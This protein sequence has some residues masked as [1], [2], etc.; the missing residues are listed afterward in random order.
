MQSS[1]V[2]ATFKAQMLKTSDV[3]KNF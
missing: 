2:N 1:A 3:L